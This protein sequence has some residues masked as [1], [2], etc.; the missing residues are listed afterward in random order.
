MKLTKKK[1]LVMILS[2]VWSL[3]IFTV[4]TYAWVSRSWEPELEYSEVTIATSGAL[5]ITIEDK[6]TGEESIFNEV[7]LNEYTNTTSFSLKQVS[8]ADGVSFLSADFTPTLEGKVPVYNAETDGKYIK[9][10][11]WLVA[12]PNN[13][14][15]I[16]NIKDVFIH[17]ETKIEYTNSG[18]EADLEQAIRIS[19]ELP[20]QTGIGSDVYILGKD[21]NS[22]G[23]Y[24]YHTGAT[25]DALGEDV[26]DDYH[27]D[28][29]TLNPD[30]TG[31]HVMYPLHYFD[32]SDASKTLCRV[33]S[34]VRQKVV[35]RIWL[36]GCDPNCVSGIAG[37]RFSLTLKFDTKDVEN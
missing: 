27:N 19:I 13:D 12:Q 15:T 4:A 35:V 22:T 37:E 20:R 25:T 36:E 14:P 24:F 34:S 7:D 3:S 18:V 2:L 10:E 23:D 21:K 29:N 17:P 8:S 1:K 31:R 30:T 26:F 28:K 33:T 5:V 6:E 16:D 9:T 11:F 32:G